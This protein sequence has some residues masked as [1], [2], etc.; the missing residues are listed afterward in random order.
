M[1][2]LGLAFTAAGLG[3][4]EDAFRLEG[5]VDAKWN[6]LG[7]P[8]APPLTEAWRE[9]DLG[10]ARARL[11]EARA[12]A[13]FDEGRAMTWDQAIKLARASQVAPLARAREAIG[14]QGPSWA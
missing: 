14:E 13:A 2:I 9:R 3:R 10:P 7:V 11:G 5:A 12:D 4:D 1:E 8:H 6:E